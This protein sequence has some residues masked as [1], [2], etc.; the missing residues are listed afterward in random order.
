MLAVTFTGFAVLFRGLTAP[1]ASAAPSCGSP[2]EQGDPSYFITAAQAGWGKLIQLRYNTRNRCAWGVIVNSS[3]DEEIWLDH[4]TTGGNGWEPRLS[5]TTCRHAL[6]AGCPH[7]SWHTDE[8]F[9]DADALMRA[10]VRIAEGR[11]L[12]TDWY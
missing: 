10:C 8:A 5:V 6:F 11:I 1:I 9:S 7:D 12:C 4:S 3:G 2:A